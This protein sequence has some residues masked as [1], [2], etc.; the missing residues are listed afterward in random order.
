MSKH[1]VSTECSECGATFT[2]TSTSAEAVQFC[3]FCGD[4][5]TLPYDDIDDDGLLDDD[6]DEDEFDGFNDEQDDRS[7]DE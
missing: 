6:I 2:V 1:Q 4:G 7:D 3:P 5:V